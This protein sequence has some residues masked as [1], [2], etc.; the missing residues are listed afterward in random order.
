MTGA[1]VIFTPLLPP[2]YFVILRFCPPDPSALLVQRF[3][4]H[5]Q[6]VS[7]DELVVI[8]RF[9]EWDFKLSVHSIGKDLLVIGD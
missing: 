4:I 7:S 1:R 5:C 8:Q 3:L 9:E 2:S 6:S